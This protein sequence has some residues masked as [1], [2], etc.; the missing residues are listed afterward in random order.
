MAHAWC[1]RNKAEGLSPAGK[2]A[3]DPTHYQ[4]PQEDKLSMSELGGKI[5][6]L[7]EEDRGI[8]LTPN[9]LG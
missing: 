8:V 4:E 1:A 9:L 2:G 6:P 5:N 7:T 3:R